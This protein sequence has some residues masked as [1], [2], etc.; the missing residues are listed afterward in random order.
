MAIATKYWTWS[1]VWTKIKSELDIDDDDDFIDE[2]EAI[3][4][5]N[6]AIDEAESNIMTLCEDYFLARDTITL[7]SSTDAYVLPATIYAHKIRDIVYY[8]NNDI[9]KLR[10]IRGLDKFLSY[11]H[12][13]VNPTSTE[14]YCYFIVNDTAGAPEILLSPVAY[15][16]GQY[17]EIWFIRQANRIAT[18]ADVID[19]PEFAS[20][21]MEYLRE[22]VEYK[23]GAGNPRHMIA[24]ERLKEI[25][26]DMVDTLQT[27]VPDDD[28]QIIPDL[29]AYDDLN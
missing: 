26:Q 3:G 28:N 25:R 22:R 19:I 16:S 15:E 6:D 13:R 7:V 24:M 12:A 9:Y 27:M 20:F 18:G 17:L 29:S 4:Y 2:T 14:E 11:R 21:V 23:R 8:K 1:E 10:R 5:A